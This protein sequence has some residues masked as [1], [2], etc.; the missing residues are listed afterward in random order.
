MHLYWPVPHHKL[1]LHGADSWPNS[2][3]SFDPLLSSGK[4]MGWWYG[5]PWARAR[6]GKFWPVTNPCLWAR[7]ATR[8]QFFFGLAVFHQLPT[9]QN[10]TAASHCPCLLMPR[11]STNHSDTVKAYTTT[12]NLSCYSLSEIF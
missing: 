11:Q 12:G 3:S 7:V 8:V 4:I 6:V 10:L 2:L 5:L 1:E 9:D